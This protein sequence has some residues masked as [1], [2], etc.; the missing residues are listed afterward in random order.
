MTEARE[1]SKLLVIDDNRVNRLLLIRGL[2][3]Q[4]H[5]VASAENGRQGMEMLRAGPYD[6]VLLDIEMPEMD[7]FQVLEQLLHDPILGDIPVIMTSASDE[8]DRVVKCIE[9]GAEDYLTKPLN[10]VLLRARVNASLEKKRL[11]D[12]Q[13]RLFRSFAAPEVAEE[14]LRS[15][16]SL[17]GK[18]M[19][20][21]AMFADI[22][23]FTSLA[24]NQDPED[25]FEMLNDYFAL[26]FDAITNHGGTLTQM[27][28]DGLLAVFGAPLP[29]DIHRLQAV[30]AA[31]EM[32]ENLEVFNAEQQQRQK[33]TVQIGIGIASGTLIAGYSG[34]K[35]RATYTCVGDT[36][37]LAARIE[38]HT[39]TAGRP[40]L[41]DQSTRDGLPAEIAVEELG[42]VLFKGKTQSVE[43]FSVYL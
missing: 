10:P 6:L 39:K 14:L 38:A 36:V 18:H 32:I 43:V 29:N 33:T 7:G 26:M 23:S 16:L 11:R 35:Q 17:G 3:Q 24:E 27:M 1:P 21:S 9:M 2:E 12:A 40:I 5:V 25:T 4:G 15:G 41:I 42:P 8:L 37:N 20:A 13:R 22:R 28:G 30:L 34:T 19:E 31:R